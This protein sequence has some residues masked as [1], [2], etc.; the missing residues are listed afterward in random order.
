M[1][2]RQKKKKLNLEIKKHN[3][4]IRKQIESWAFIADILD[5]RRQKMLFEVIYETQ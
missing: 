1:N 2:K 5:P 3:L 4:E